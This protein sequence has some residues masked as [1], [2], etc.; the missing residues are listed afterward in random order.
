MPRPDARSVLERLERYYDAAPRAGAQTEAVGP[1]TL[2]VSTGD[3][4][5]YARPRLGLATSIEPSAVTSVLA[6]Q[7]ELGVPEAL[8]WVV[9]TT[10]SLSAAARAAG[11]HVV[12]LPLLVLDHPLTVPTP[13][14]VRVRRVAA[15]EPDLERI[16]AVAAVAFAHAGT[17]TGL[18][19]SRERDALAVASTLDRSRLRERLAAGTT[20]LVVAEDRDGP[21]ASGAHQPIDDVTEV[22]GVATLPSA[23]RRGIGAAVTGALVHHAMASGLGLVFLSAASDDVARIYERLGFRRAAR[24]GIAGI[25]GA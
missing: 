4:P 22:V 3:F 11:L 20:V 25:D 6:R 5:F 9:E 10:P 23:R 17:A 21:I 19:G 24:A 2:F 13:T 1:F 15:D 8:E 7:R 16:L 12:E 14:E 18:A